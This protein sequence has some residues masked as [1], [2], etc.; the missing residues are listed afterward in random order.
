MKIRSTLHLG[1][2]PV[3]ILLVP[4]LSETLDHLLLKLAAAVLFHKTEP[5]VSPSSQ[6][7]ALQGQDFLPDLVKVNDT[8]DVTLWIECGKTTLH[9]IEKVSKR[10]CTLIEMSHIAFNRSV[11]P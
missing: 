11:T 9:K 8:N 4:I 5:I 1:D 2:Q 7:P 6:H 10:C 3:Q